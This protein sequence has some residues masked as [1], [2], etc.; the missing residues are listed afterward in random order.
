MHNHCPNI[1]GESN[2]ILVDI[3]CPHCKKEH[4]RWLD[5]KLYDSIA[6]SIKRKIINI[7]N[8]EMEESK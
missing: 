5:K 2:S 4:I 6:N 7:L 1:V 8:T 3:W